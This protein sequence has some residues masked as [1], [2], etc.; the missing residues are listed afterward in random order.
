[1]F[2]GQGCAVHSC[3]YY[4]AAMRSSMEIRMKRSIR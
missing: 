3:K 1:V 4:P 2:S